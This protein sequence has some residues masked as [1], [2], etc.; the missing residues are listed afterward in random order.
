V[1]SGKLLSSFSPATPAPT[2]PPGA[3]VSNKN[4]SDHKEILSVDGSRKEAPPTRKTSGVTADESCSMSEENHVEIPSAND[5]SLSEAPHATDSSGVTTEEDYSGSETDESSSS[6]SDSDATLLSIDDGSVSEARTNESSGGTTFESSMNSSYSDHDA[7]QSAVLS[8]VTDPTEESNF[9][10]VDRQL[11]PELSDGIQLQNVKGHGESVVLDSLST[12]KSRDSGPAVQNSN[13]SD[14]YTRRRN[15][16]LESL[17]AGRVERKKQLEHNSLSLKMGLPTFLCMEDHPYY[18]AQQERKVQLLGQ[19]KMSIREASAVKSQSIE[20]NFLDEL[21]AAHK[22][23]HQQ[24]LYTQHLE[25]QGQK[26]EDFPI[27]VCLDGYVNDAWLLKTLQA[28]I[29]KQQ[30]DHAE[31]VFQL[32]NRI[33]CDA[34][35]YELRIRELENRLKASK[36]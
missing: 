27:P 9:A 21:V 25:T 1:Y 3:G 5:R 34:M 24:R 29:V 31:E 10:N 13:N 20:E 18:L 28:Q 23:I 6:Q 14:D 12:R 30:R 11:T 8:L 7:I 4:H 16:R 2:A 15:K 35:K 19:K 33:T 17:R 22:L 32:Q 36:L 26:R